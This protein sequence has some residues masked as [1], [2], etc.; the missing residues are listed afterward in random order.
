[1]N[2]ELERA[3]MEMA[4]GIEWFDRPG[5]RA[6]N[7]ERAIEHLSRAIEAFAR[8]QVI[9]RWAVAHYE[10]GLA[11]GARVLGDRRQ[12]LVTSIA[13]YQEARRYFIEHDPDRYAMVAQNLGSTLQDLAA[14]DPLNETCALAAIVAAREGMAAQARRGNPVDWASAA[15]NLAMILRDALH[16]PRAE[17]IDEAIDL[18]RAVLGVFT[19]GS[20]PPVQSSLQQGQEV[21]TP[22]DFLRDRA[23]TLGNLGNSLTARLNGD[24]AENLEAAITSHLQALRLWEELGDLQAQAQTA[25]NLGHCYQ[26]RLLGAAYENWEASVRYY[27]RAVELHRR[28]GSP[29]FEL[30]QTEQ[31]LGT[32]LLFVAQ[33]LGERPRAE[34][35]REIEEGIALLHS[36]LRVRTRESFPYHWAMTTSMLALAHLHRLEGDRAE[37]IEGAIQHFEAI[38]R[39]GEMPAQTRSHQGNAY[40]RRMRGDR[41]V[42]VEKAMECYRIALKGFEGAGLLENSLEARL[43]LAD[44]LELLGRGA[45]AMAVLRESVQRIESARSGEQ[46]TRSKRRWS[47]HASRFLDRLVSLSWKESPGEALRWSEFGRGRALADV[48]VGRRRRPA[49]VSDEQLDRYAALQELHLDL[50]R[51]LDLITHEET[52]EVVLQRM[53]EARTALDALE[54][55]FRVADPSWSPGA[56]PLTLAELLD[57]DVPVL[58][59]RVNADATYVWLLRS[60]RPLAARRL[61]VPKR[62]EVQ[63]LLLRWLAASVTQVLFESMEPQ[64]GEL[65]NVLIG[66]LHGFVGESLPP[67]QD[68][69]LVV[70]ASQSLGVLPLHAAWRMEDGERRFWCDDYA[71]GYAPSIASLRAARRSRVET[72]PSLLAVADPTA[73]EPLPWAYVEA[74]QV[75]K[76][77]VGPT[78]LLSGQAATRQAVLAELTRCPRTI[79]FSCHGTWDM[80]APWFRAGLLLADAQ[81]PLPNLT[82]GDISAADLSG[83]RLAILSACETGMS[84]AADPADEFIGLPAT[85]LA[86]GASTVVGS[87]WSV[88]DAPTALL[89]TH[90]FSGSP[91]RP[92]T[93]LHAAQ[94]WL[95]NATL[96]E[97]TAAV[98]ALEVEP[99]MREETLRLFCERGPRPCAHPYWWAALTCVGA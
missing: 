73:V 65:W 44:A 94:K 35:S 40:L 58:V 83:C 28:A 10:L 2:R 89:V 19:G 4:A 53:R 95:R 77:F 64:L 68:A 32:T 76:A 60:G 66:A 7:I 22:R 21:Y 52:R 6:G 74:L 78:T 42:N 49:N 29:S 82:L 3:E 75:S 54:R 69:E 92:L 48:Q 47:V 57:V 46:W 98:A 87:L 13:H 50:E 24:R 17:Q 15:N 18:H 70:V 33:R 81:P 34:R 5:D 80:D 1:M 71:I 12:N 30:A 99:H 55:S 96:G 97:L 67:G 8:E 26:E 41:R 91:D 85:F 31:N 59:V 86:A 88:D 27:R 25:N 23:W 20:T 63:R 14:L 72:K 39:H 45:E 43:G 36:S 37:N 90:A 79:L 62:E 56:A 84:D 51:R 9:E 38:A 61:D 93:R 11:H 16:G